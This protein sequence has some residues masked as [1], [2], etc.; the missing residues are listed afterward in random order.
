MLFRSAKATI[1]L[2][3]EGVRNRTKKELGG[4][5]LPQGIKDSEASLDLCMEEGKKSGEECAV[6]HVQRATVILGNLIL[7]SKLRPELGARYQKLEPEIRKLE[8]PFR[9]CVLKT[10]APLDKKFLEELDVCGTTLTENALEFLL[11]HAG[12]EEIGRAHV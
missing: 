8:H 9:E 6:E 3:R 5:S 4:E 1:A 7:D 2:A 12:D 11:A 10:R